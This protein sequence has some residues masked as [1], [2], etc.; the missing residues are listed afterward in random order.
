MVALKE[1]KVERIEATEESEIVWTK[2]V[3][4]EWDNSLFPRAKS[5]YQGANIPGRKVEPLNWY[6]S[7]SLLQ[8]RSVTD[9][10]TGPVACQHMLKL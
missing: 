5:W 2:R 1:E 7:R 3:H 6:V 4:E 10:Y 9:V 8:G